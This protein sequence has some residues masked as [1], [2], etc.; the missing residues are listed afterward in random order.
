MAVVGG[1]LAFRLIPTIIGQCDTW[2]R[3]CTLN[4]TF[5]IFAPSPTGQLIEY[6]YTSNDCVFNG[7]TWTC[8]T[9]IGGGE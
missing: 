5:S 4:Q 6:D 9:R 3:K 2:S 8:T 1:V 7:F